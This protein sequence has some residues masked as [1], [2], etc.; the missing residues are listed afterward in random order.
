MAATWTGRGELGL[1]HANRSRRSVQAL[2]EAAPTGPTE[3]VNLAD[4]ATIVPI[5]RPPVG[6][7]IT[8]GWLRGWFW[9][10]SIGSWVRSPHVDR[11]LT[12]L[13][14]VT[15]GGSL[16]AIQVLSASGRFAL[17]ADSVVLSGGSSIT[18]DFECTGYHWESL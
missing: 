2:T 1:A 15:G 12:D 4:V 11:D 8:S 10:D 6:E 14:G 7:T 16:P 17:I 13:S 18:V 3:G 9:P 5:V